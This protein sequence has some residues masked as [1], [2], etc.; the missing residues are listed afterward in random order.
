[1][2]IHSQPHPAGA[3]QV[4]A[5]LPVSGNDALLNI[6]LFQ[7]ALDKAAGLDTAGYVSGYRGSP[8]GALDSVAA[9]RTKEFEAAGV[10]F[11]PGLNEDLAAT[12]VWGTQQLAF[13][14]KRK[15]DGVF[16]IWYGKGPGLDRSIDPI[17][18]GN[19]AGTSPK[20][21]ILLLVGDDPT[22]KS[23]SVAYQSEQALISALVP[24]LNPSN[25][26]EMTEFGL[27]GIAMSRASGCWIALKCLTDL[28]D[29]STSQPFTAEEFDAQIPEGLPDD[30]HI[31]WPDLMLEQERRLLRKKL[32]VV[33]RYVRANGLNR[34]TLTP[35]T[36]KLGI[37]ASG[38]TYAVVHE[39]LGHL[40]LTEAQ[41][42]SLGIGLFKVGCPWPLEPETIRDFARKYPEVL[43]IEEKRNLIEDQLARVLYGLPDGRRPALSGKETPDGT[44]LMES[45]GELNVQDVL[46]VLT[47]R[48]SALG[49]AHAAP[50]VL[51]D[52]AQVPALSQ[53]SIWYC[54]GCPH[55]RS[56]KT[57]EG[58]RTIAGIGCH[59]MSIFI[60]PA[61][62]S[63]ATHMGG[64]GASWIGQAHFTN[65]KHVFQ[66]I[67]DGTFAH[68]G[69]TAIRAAVV[70]GTSITYKILYN[71]AVAMTGGQEVEGGITV[72]DIY[73]QLRGIGVTE[74]RVLSEDPKRFGRGAPFKALPRGALKVIEAELR[75]VP[76]C[77]AIIYDQVCAAEKRRRRKRNLMEDPDKRIFINDRVCEGCGDCGDVSNCV[78][79]KPLETA[80]GRKRQ[81]DQTACNKDYSCAE[82]FCPSFVALSGLKKR[83][84][85]PVTDGDTAALPDSPVAKLDGAE[86]YNVVL[87]GI[88]GT[89]VVTAAAMIAGAARVE[90]LE[91][92]TLDQTGLAQKNGPVQ[93][94]VRLA[95]ASGAI[96]TPKVPSAQADVI[97]GCDS[98]VAGSL[99]SLS[100]MASAR[101]RVVLNSDTEPLAA[102]AKLPDLQT[103]FAAYRAAIADLTGQAAVSELAAKTEAITAT[104]STASVNIVILGY[105]VQ[106]GLLPISAAAFEQAIRQSGKAVDQN[107]RAFTHGRSLA[108]GTAWTAPAEPARDPADHF[109]GEL[110]QYQ[111]R[112]YAERYRAVLRSVR[113]VEPEDQTA[114]SAAVTVS[115]YKLM[116]YKDEYEV[117]R[118]YAET[119]F[120]D[121]IKAEWEGRPKISF[122]FLP[123]AL[124]ALRGGR[125]AKITFGGWML[126][127]LRILAKGRA[128]RGSWFD[129]FGYAQDRQLERALRDDYIRTMTALQRPLDDA[130]Y[131]A[132]L[133]FAQLPEAIRGYGHVKTASARRVL[134]KWFELQETL[135]IIPGKETLGR[136]LT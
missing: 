65:E 91:V 68:S 16:G 131:A 89:G 40:G 34:E 72:E 31:R 52:L 74:I 8:L 64:E 111:N 129:P 95:A 63:G 17:K 50:P 71:D 105:C 25:V 104:G 119:D 45:D 101:T 128:L 107:L 67:G 125:P 133:A 55:N 20:G 96:D 93:S 22:A 19:F 53:R 110:A 11:E 9:R 78:A 99:P 115:L 21:G 10:V 57:I 127:V 100:L 13:D 80:F 27:H 62:T 59:S 46:P 36:P 2:S 26:R 132:A 113:E 86:P 48:L 23:S 75:E 5:P 41:C 66:N 24:V 114:L 58:S 84:A 43:V 87:T 51:P 32:D 30:L 37:V 54:A 121:R 61:N 134:T 92:L 109:S 90:G 124:G 94:H 98:V 6:A 79:I 56:T 123:P 116:A 103:D 33:R 47:A 77:T 130:A 4:E 14:P 97:I 49:I 29:S 85:R 118:L 69:L 76:G 1:M 7:S 112:A 15:H 117:A 106:S 120:L 102:F 135:G 73:H 136:F 82:G 60:D 3:D 70:S 126:P 38:K 88:G 12:A 39:A 83:K 42:Q 18:H 108:A 44:R 81:I 35:R 122:H 28:V